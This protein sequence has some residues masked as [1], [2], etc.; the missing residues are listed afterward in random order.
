MLTSYE[1]VSGLRN[2]KMLTA[3]RADPANG[4]IDT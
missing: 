1:L 3:A 2:L 4:H